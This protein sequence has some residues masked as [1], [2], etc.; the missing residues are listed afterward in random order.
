MMIKIWKCVSV[1]ISAIALLALASCNSAFMNGM[2][3]G[4][5]TATTG[6]YTPSYGAGTTSYSAPSTSGNMDYLLDPRYAAMQV[7]QQQ[8]SYNNTFNQLLNKTVADVQQ[9]ESDFKR[10]YRESYRQSTGQMPTEEQVNN[11]YSNYLAG[12][13]GNGGGSISSST[14]S[15]S[16]SDPVQYESVACGTCGGTGT[17]VKNDTPTMGISNTRHC[18]ICNKTVSGSH[19]HAPCPVCHGSKTEKRRVR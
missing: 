18:S 15:S 1:A 10:R 19:Y 6:M 4:M 14:S 16:G 5:Y 9:E 8:A 13:Y 11:A 7:Q 17:I 3:D 2:L 12:K